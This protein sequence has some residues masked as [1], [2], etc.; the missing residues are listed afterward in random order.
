MGRVHH[1]YYL[2]D[3]EGRPIVNA[4]INLYL[5]GTTSAATVYPGPAAS[6]AI[7]QSLWTTGTSGFFNFYVGDQFEELYVGYEPD[8][9]FD[10]QWAAS[11]TIYNDDVIPSGN[12]EN[13]QLLTQIFTVDETSTTIIKNKMIS[14][15]LAYKWDT[16]PDSD[17]SFNVHNL[18][19][20]DVNDS[21]DTT[22]TKLVSDD[23]MNSLVSFP[24]VSAGLTTISASGTLITQQWIYPSAWSPSGDTNVVVDIDT[25]LPGRNRPYPIVQIYDTATG[26]SLIP[27]KISDIDDTSLRIVMASGY[28]G[29]LT[30]GSVSVTILGE[31]RPKLL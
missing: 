22:N 3:K 28:A 18:Y 9:E 20:V 24:L 25:N 16:H 23:L 21:T 11:G 1:W 31:I 2:K 6:A 4:N 10:L 29:E 19:P 12:I 26:D 5:S 7:D 30:L 17:Y 15:F 14:N 27:V 8:Q 13:A